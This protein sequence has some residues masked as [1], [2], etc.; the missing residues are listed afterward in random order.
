MWVNLPTEAAA[1]HHLVHPHAALG[2]P[3]HPRD[4]L[5]VEVR[6]LSGRPN[7]DPP[8]WIRRNQR[9][10]SLHI[11]VLDARIEKPLLHYRRRISK[12]RLQVTAANLSVG[13]DV[14]SRMYLRRPGLHRLKRV[15]NRSQDL[16]VHLD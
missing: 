3:Q 8:S 2:Q 1:G 14:S 13:A 9:D 5:A 16:I 10:L 7:R 12:R 6:V 11:S 4:L 15:Q